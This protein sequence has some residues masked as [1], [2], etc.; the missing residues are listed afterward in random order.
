[1]KRWLALPPNGRGHVSNRA[2]CEVYNSDVRECKD[3]LPACSQTA[4][5]QYS[6]AAASQDAYRQMM[7]EL[8]FGWAGILTNNQ[9]FPRTA[10]F[11]FKKRPKR[12]A[13]VQ[14]IIDKNTGF[15]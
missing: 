10:R 8:C 6:T 1:M 9:A 13:S 11:V 15:M 14:T 5:W 7:A 3:P 12:K 2:A 4:P